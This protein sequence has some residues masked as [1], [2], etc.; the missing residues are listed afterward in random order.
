MLF[1]YGVALEAFGQPEAAL[2]YISRAVENRRKNRPGTRF[3]GQMLEGQAL[4]L[5]EL[6]QNR[7]AQQLLDEA[8]GIRKNVGQKLD[9]NYKIARLRLALA[10][11]KSD[12]A[13]SLV[14]QYYGAS[15]A[16]APLTTNYLKNAEI[17]AEI[18]L[19]RNDGTAAAEM[20]RRALEAIASSPAR[21]YL[22]VYEA[23]A[24]SSAGQAYL[25]Q[26]DAD[27]A[28]PLLEH[29]VQIYSGLLDSRSPEL[30]AAHAL[31]GVCYWK[32]RNPRKAI[33]SYGQACM[34]LRVHK[35]LS[36]AYHRPVEALA[37]QLGR[38]APAV[39][40]Y[41]QDSPVRHH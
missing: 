1:Q 4:V 23:R 16:D 6:G 29:A 33:A 20:A 3:L 32:L 27:K 24:I 25:L 39:S 7:R 5:I 9:S 21:N 41:S 8:A 28:L 40:A 26:G 34:G 18:A 10:L 31:V 13:E 15:A 17:R 38:R 2:D 11:R 37:R 14:Q 36:E 35:Q 12:E 30:V 22:Q 19:L